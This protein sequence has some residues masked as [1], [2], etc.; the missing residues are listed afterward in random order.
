[1]TLA[2]PPEPKATGS[3][4]VSRAPAS[5]VFDLSFVSAEEAFS[6]LPPVWVPRG[7]DEEQREETNHCLTSGEVA[8]DSA[9]AR[10]WMVS[11]ARRA[12]SMASHP[13]RLVTHRITRELD[14]AEGLAEECVLGRTRAIF[15]PVGP[16]T[17]KP[18][19]LP[20]SNRKAPL[21]VLAVGRVNLLALRKLRFQTLCVAH[22]LQFQPLLTKDVIA[23]QHSLLSQNSGRGIHGLRDGHVGRRVSTEDAVVLLPEASAELQTDFSGPRA[24]L[25]VPG[26]SVPP[27]QAPWPRGRSLPG[28]LRRGYEWI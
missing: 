22:R 23:D 12:D 4:P 27:T 1:M 13:A 2:P 5:A 16:R 26:L 15:A 19:H 10:A 11:T 9:D 17:E 28:A 7:Q 8:V 14:A 24:L 21:E 20:P 6:N 3:N 18:G 25:R